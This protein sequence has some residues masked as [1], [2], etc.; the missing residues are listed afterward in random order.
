MKHCLFPLAVVLVVALTLLAG[1]LQGRMSNRWGPSPDTL[2]AARE[3]ER[4]PHEFGDWR[5]KASEDLSKG[6][7]EML[8]CVGYFVRRYENQRTGDIVSVTL[9]LGP[10]GPI[11]AHT[12]EICFPSQNYQS[13][14]QRQQVAIPG[15]SGGENLFWSLDYKMNDIRGD[16][17]RVY[18][19]WS[20]GGRWEAPEDDARFAF[21]GRPYLYK[22]QLSGLLPPGAIPSSRDPC[23]AFL[24]A[25]VPVAGKY[26]AKP[27]AK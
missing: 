17:L 3:L 24:R 6:T 25:F 9:L 7:R 12:P 26:L 11:A 27:S 1:V 14:N 2:A 16:L 23:A 5:L 10:P 4:I 18:Y 22:I 8:Q 21:A 15:A 20:A 13:R 19:A